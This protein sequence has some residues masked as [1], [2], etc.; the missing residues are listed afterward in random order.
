LYEDRRD[1]ELAPL[2]DPFSSIYLRRAIFRYI[3]EGL[4]IALTPS[5]ATLPPRAGVP[6]AGARDWELA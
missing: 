2:S 4:R 3:N 1:G 6:S 5:V